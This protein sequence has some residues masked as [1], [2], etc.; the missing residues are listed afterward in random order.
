MRIMKFTSSLKYILCLLAFVSPLALSDVPSELASEENT[1]TTEVLVISQGENSAQCQETKRV[2]DQLKKHF[3]WDGFRQA[4]RNWDVAHGYRST[5]YKKTSVGY[6]PEKKLTLAKKGNIYALKELSNEQSLYQR[7]ERNT[8]NLLFLAAVHGSTSA[9]TEMMSLEAW[10]KIGSKPPLS[11]DSPELRVK[12][13]GVYA[14]AYAVLLRG[15]LRFKS[16]AYSYYQDANLHFT[17][18]EW[19]MMRTEGKN[20]VEQ[21]EKERARL[22]LKPFSKM[23]NSANFEFVRAK[24]ADIHCQIP[25]DF[26]PLEN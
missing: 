24:W 4:D 5:E 25:R 11:Q 19:A 16:L 20:I 2:Y 22:K 1:L 10:L 12:W 18:E 14:W 9:L 13:V 21:L 8:N 15:D 3:S 6:T 23:E 7:I 26:M 17:N